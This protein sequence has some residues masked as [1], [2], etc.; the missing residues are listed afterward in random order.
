MPLDMFIGYL[1]AVCSLGL[2]RTDFNFC[3]IYVYMYIYGFK[4]IVYLES[5]L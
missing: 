3:I 5:Y 4:D 2:G 1:M